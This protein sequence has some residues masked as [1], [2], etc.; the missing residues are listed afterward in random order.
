MPPSV[1]NGNKQQY[2]DTETS[3]KVE[4]AEYRHL[5]DSFASGLNL[6]GNGAAGA[7]AAGGAGAGGLF[8][9]NTAGGQFPN[10]GRCVVYF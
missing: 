4:T 7:N 3:N 2:H 1:M 6:N 5:A 9:W 8:A 10:D